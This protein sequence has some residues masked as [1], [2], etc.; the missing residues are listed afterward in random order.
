MIVPTIG[1]IVWI[2]DRRFIYAEPVKTATQTDEEHAAAVADY[3]AEYDLLQPEAAIVTWVHADD[4]ITVCAFHKEGT[5]R[6]LQNLLLRQDDVAVPD[7]TVFW[8]E[9]MPYQV[10]QAGGPVTPLPTPVVTD[11]ILTT[12][13]VV[14]PAPA[15]V[16]L[17]TPAM[18]G[19]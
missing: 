17:T 6:P 16:P 15:F 4:E 10:K 12:P 11:P 3:K 9:W 1:R 13:A 14:P 5:S 8:A 2:K 7:E 19:K 18:P